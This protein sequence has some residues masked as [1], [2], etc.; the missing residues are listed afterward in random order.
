MASWAEKQRQQTDYLNNMWGRGI[1]NRN[2]PQFNP[3]ANAYVSNTPQ[4]MLGPSMGQNFMDTFQNDWQWGGSATPTW[5]T[6][7]HG[8]DEANLANTLGQ[9]SGG[10]LVDRLGGLGNMV[11]LGAQLWGLKQKGDEIS[12]LEKYRSQM[13]QRANA[14]LALDRERM[15]MVRDERDILKLAR[16]A[17]IWAQRPGD[18]NANP[19]TNQLVSQE[20]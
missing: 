20:V 14:A 17:N 18:P 9:D 2:T 5:K 12:N 15:G 4:A 3:E 11:G 13:G 6:Y 19:F 16:K 8:L 10:G 1:H 7:Q